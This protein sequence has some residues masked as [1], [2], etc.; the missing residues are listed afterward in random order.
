MGE[1]LNRFSDW[2]DL[3]ETQQFLE[4]ATLLHREAERM[5]KE[6]LSDELYKFLL[7]VLHTPTAVAE[8]LKSLSDNARA[9]LK[10]EPTENVRWLYD[11]VIK[12][13]ALAV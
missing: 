10:H 1:N 3:P 4:R 12:D 8:I 11:M 5:C 9:V 7:G 13:S 2:V 6:N